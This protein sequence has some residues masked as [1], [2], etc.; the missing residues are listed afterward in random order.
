[1][2]AFISCI[3]C[4]IIGLIMGADRRITSDLVKHIMELEKKNIEDK[5]KSV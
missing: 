5:E 4:W 1:M 3:L 2:I